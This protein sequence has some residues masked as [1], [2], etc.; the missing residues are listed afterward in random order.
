MKDSRIHNHRGGGVFLACNEDTNIKISNS[1]I[2]FNQVCGINIVGA[3][4]CAILEANKIENN[5]G[6]GVRL[7]LTNKS[8]LI[9]NEFRLNQNGIEAISCEPIIAYNIIEKNYKNGILA[10]TY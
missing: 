9:K 10:I 6:P 1:K 7:S 4:S 5:E 2:M 8:K 3:E